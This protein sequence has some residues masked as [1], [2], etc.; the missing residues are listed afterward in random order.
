MAT[1]ESH[2]SGRQIDEREARW[3]RPFAGAEWR[4]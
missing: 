4:A 2:F 1:I 3:V